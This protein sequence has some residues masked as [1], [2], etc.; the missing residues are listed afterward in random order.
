MATT[1][2]QT[3]TNAEVD[4]MVVADLRGALT[5]RGLD[6]SGLKLELVSRLKAAIGT[7]P[8]PGVVQD[9]PPLTGAKIDSMVVASL[10]DEL[11]LRGLDSTGRK[12]DLVLRL[13]ASIMPQ[14][15]LALVG[16]SPALLNEAPR[17]PPLLSGGG[18]RLSIAPGSPVDNDIMI[19]VLPSAALH[20]LL[21]SVDSAHSGANVRFGAAQLV[22]GAACTVS[23]ECRALPLGSSIKFDKLKEIDE[24]L[25]R[26]LSNTR[27]PRDWDEVLSVAKST[28]GVAN[29]A[30]HLQVSDFDIVAA[31]DEST[32]LPIHSLLIGD[33]SRFLDYLVIICLTG[34]FAC[35]TIQA[36]TSRTLVNAFMT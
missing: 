6:S 20:T 23:A 17:D 15:P 25:I 29:P 3:L 7:L 35:P 31:P 4:A 1:E 30:L 18:A 5:A 33:F 13:K 11:T 2:N 36:V 28:L 34:S 32:R 19:S 24:L 27:P 22:L 12:A 14:L 21:Q 16:A 10:R 8:Q 9:P 26:G